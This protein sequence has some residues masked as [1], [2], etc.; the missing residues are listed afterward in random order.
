MKYYVLDGEINGRPIRG[1]KFSSRAAAEKAM[2]V[3]IYKEGLQV[4]DNRF[5]SKHTEEFVCD[6]CSRFFVSRV[7]CSK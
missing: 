5:P 3:I 1:K 7:I 6:R 4:Q 2:E